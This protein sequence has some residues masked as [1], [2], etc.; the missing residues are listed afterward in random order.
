MTKSSRPSHV[1]RPRWRVLSG[2]DVVLGPGKADLLEAIGRTGSL[3]LAAQALSMSYMRA[4]KLVQ[5]M[6]G[7]FREPLVE[8]ERGGAR[9]GAATLTR[10]GR[11]VLTL[12]REMEKKSLSAAA[13]SWRRLRRHL[14]K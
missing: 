3:R 7:A 14:L 5:T 11:A 4:W 1:L 10:T 13:T 2:Q 9:H 12:Y 8:T 6:N